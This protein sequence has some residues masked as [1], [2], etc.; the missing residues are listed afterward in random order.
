M[1]HGVAAVMYFSTVAAERVKIKN[2]TPSL[3]ER[4][5]V[6]NVFTSNAR[7]SACGLNVETC[8]L[9]QGVKEVWTGSGNPIRRGGKLLGKADGD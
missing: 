1:F 6:F 4:F 3:W 7:P 8:V 5:V 9:V 2:I